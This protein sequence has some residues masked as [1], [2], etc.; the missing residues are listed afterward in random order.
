[1]NDEHVGGVGLEAKRAAWRERERLEENLRN[2][3]CEEHYIMLS[4]TQREPPVDEHIAQCEAIQKHLEE[5]I[6][7]FPRC[8]TCAHDGDGTCRMNYPF[9]AWC[10]EW[11]PR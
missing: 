8:E 3:G 9:R 6:L 7:S 10:G 5:E 1:M 11:E 2:A 4:G